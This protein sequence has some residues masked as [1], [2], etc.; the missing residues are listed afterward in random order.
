MKR[1][2]ASIATALL[3]CAVSASSASAKGKSKAYT[4]GQDFIIAG[5]TVKAGTYVFS[6]D[7]EKNEL[8]VI[9]RKT[10][11]VVARAE[12]RAEQMA[13]GP[14]SLGVQL[15]GNATPM[16]FASIAFESKQII[17]V[18]ASAARQ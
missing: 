11:E 18:S 10:K 7:D 14:I 1:I 9:N 2:L 5:T 17:K 16:T 3:I 12:A 4:V 15:T 6:F 13:K 8:T